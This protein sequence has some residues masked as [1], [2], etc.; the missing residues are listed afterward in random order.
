MREILL[1]LTQS[2]A[3]VDWIGLLFGAIGGIVML[4]FSII[5]SK[6]NKI[7]KNQEKLG[8]EMVGVLKDASY[9]VRDIA[10]LQQDNKSIHNTLQENIDLLSKIRIYHRKNHGEEL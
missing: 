9:I 8:E 2:E 7:E 4:L 10:E 5:L 1:F 3:S 6:M